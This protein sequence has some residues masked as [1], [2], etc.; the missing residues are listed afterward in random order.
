MID[1]AKNRPLDQQPVARLRFNYA[2]YGTRI[3]TLEPLRG[4]CGWLILKLFSVEA[5]GNLE[6]H[7]VVSAVTADG[8]AL[9]ED[10]PEKLLRLPAHLEQSEFAAEGSVLLASD[11]EQRKNQLLREINQRNMGYFEQEVAK[12]DAWADDLKLGLEQEIKAI[13][14]EIK[15]LRRIAATAATLEEKLDYQKLQREL[16]GKRSKLRRELFARQDEIEEERNALIDQ[17]E[18]QLKQHVVEQTL[19]TVEWELL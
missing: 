18:A 11:L 16:E 4:Q 1:Q 6:Q 8:Q 15:E 2:A 3:S 19:F 13:D 5:L 7:L 9:P 14:G 12:L 10:D 17:L